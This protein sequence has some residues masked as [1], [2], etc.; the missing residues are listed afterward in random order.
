VLTICNEL[1]WPISSRCWALTVP[2]AGSLYLPDLIELEDA[3]FATQAL[4][5]TL[6]VWAVFFFYGQRKYWFKLFIGFNYGLFASILVHWTLQ[7]I[8]DPTF[9]DENVNL[10]QYL[11]QDAGIQPIEDIFGNLTPR[12]C[13]K[14][15]RP[16]SSSMLSLVSATAARNYIRPKTHYRDFLSNLSS[17]SFHSIVS[18]WASFAPPADWTLEIVLRQLLKLKMS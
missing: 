13:R 17:P 2:R 6:A 5:D 9:S 18:D 14:S 3:A 15:P 1:N 16:N 7:G 4:G 8:P 10:Y 12:G 11:A